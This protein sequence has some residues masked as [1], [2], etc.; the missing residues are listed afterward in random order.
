VE[1]ESMTD[2][3]FLRRKRHGTTVRGVEGCC[4]FPMGRLDSREGA[5][6]ADEIAAVPRWVSSPG[7][8]LNLNWEA[9]QPCVLLLFLSFYSLFCS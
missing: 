7:V 2:S 8:G 9:H 5:R 1:V 4:E 6:K 3:Q